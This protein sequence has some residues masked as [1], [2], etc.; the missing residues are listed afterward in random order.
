MNNDTK[1]FETFF[2]LT[3]ISCLIIGGW[4][5]YQSHFVFRGEEE[6][7]V[8]KK[9]SD[10]AFFINDASQKLDV[11]PRL[12][13]SVIYA[14]SR[15]NVNLLDSFEREYASLGNNTSIGLA[16]IRIN[17][18]KWIM[19]TV[20]DTSSVYSLDSQ[21][22]KWVPSY[23]TREDIIKLLEN[24]STN[25]L[26]AAIHLKQIIQRWHRSGYDIE[27]RPDIVMTLYSYGLFR[28]EN[29]SEIIPHANPR[30][31]FLGKVA[32]NFFNSNQLKWTI[33]VSY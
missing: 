12:L 32:A 1:Y 29:G 27:N 3:I 10:N 15:V 23:N 14:E 9:L 5:L 28:R 11:D 8:R 17:T 4:Y 25:C 26:L 31:N 13:A 20:R 16:Q 18:A 7:V 22:D 33:N 2:F 30:S 24:D 6:E 21:Y 19:D